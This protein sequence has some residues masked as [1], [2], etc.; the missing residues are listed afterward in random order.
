MKDMNAL[1]RILSPT[2][3]HMP[4][5][6]GVTTGFVSSRHIMLASWL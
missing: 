6:V 4:I 3:S 1:I 5:F 2:L